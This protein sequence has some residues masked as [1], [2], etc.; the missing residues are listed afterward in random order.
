MPSRVELRP[1]IRDDVK[2]IAEW[3]NDEEVSDAWFGRYTYD[4]PAHL[5]YEPD[6]M[7]DATQEEWDEVFH[8]P[9]H[10]PHRD[11]FSIYTEEGQHIGE[12]QL[13]ID[14]P[15]GDAQVSVLIGDKTRWHGGFGTAATLAMLEHI[16]DTLGLFRAWVDVPDYNTA[17]RNMFEHIGFQHEGTLRKSRPHHGA[18]HNSVILGML[19]DEYHQ[20]FPDGVSS[21]VI[22]FDRPT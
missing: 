14:E 17:A 18:R 16:F 13:S 20:R 15:L 3:L 4:D 9:H 8:D 6:R 2:R 19:V 11:I 12:G 7:I 21:H 22:G 10:E 1:V 5:G